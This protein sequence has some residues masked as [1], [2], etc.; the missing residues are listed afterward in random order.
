MSDILFNKPPMSPLLA[1]VLRELEAIRK[2]PGGVEEFLESE[3]AKEIER[4]MEDRIETY[5]CLFP[6]DPE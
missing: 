3:E 6:D 1:R 2:Q 4:E 5:G